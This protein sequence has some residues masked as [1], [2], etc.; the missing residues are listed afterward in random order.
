MRFAI[1]SDVHA[2]VQAWNAVLSDIAVQS[3]DRIVCLGDLVGYGADPAAVL[4]S[5]YRH[6]DAF[7][8]GNHDAVIAGRMADTWF[9]DEA[10]TALAWTRATL[11]PRARTF[12]GTWP[13]CLKGP[14]FRCAHGDFARPAA[15]TYIQAPETAMPSWERVDEPLLF[16]GHTHQPG[17]YL[18][19]ASGI[20]RRVEPQ[21]FELEPGKRYLVNVGSVGA[22]RQGDALAGYCLYDNALQTVFWRRVPYDLEACRAA[23]A[24]A[25]LPESPFGGLS[26]DPRERLRTVRAPLPFSPPQAETDHARAATETRDVLVPV[27]RR[28]RRWQRI[29]GG[30]LAAALTLASVLGIGAWRRAREF[31]ALPAAPLAPRAVAARPEAIGVEGLLVPWTWRDGPSPLLTGWRVVR[32]A[33]PRQHWHLAEL[34]DVGTVLVLKSAAPDRDFRVESQPLWLPETGLGRMQARARFRK[35][36]AFQGDIGLV[37]DLLRESPETGQTHLVPAFH[38]REPRMVRRDGWLKAQTTFDL[39]ATTQAVIVAV[40][41]RFTGAVEVQ[42]VILTPVR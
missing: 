21:D 17:I 2:N 9:T 13:L 14:G 3:V 29:A 8:L 28:A 7:A 23:L 19:G 34:L 32:Q 30:S 20:P 22:P 39:P 36:D 42:S 11:R 6:V 40:E 41:G 26:Q 1:L 33:A 37:F 16:V 15:F 5:A 10:R 35:S 31:S 27:L 18:L 24:R 4:E 12:L 25:G 38:R